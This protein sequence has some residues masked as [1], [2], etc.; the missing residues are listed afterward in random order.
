MRHLIGH[1]SIIWGT[2]KKMPFMLFPMDGTSC[3]HIHHQYSLP[4]LGAFCAASNDEE[5]MAGMK[6]ASFYN[7]KHAQTPENVARIA[8]AGIR[9]GD[10]L[11]T[12]TPGLGPMA[13]ILTRGFAPADTFMRNLVEAILSLPLRL[14]TSLTHADLVRRLVEIH[15]KHNPAGR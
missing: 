9:A 3:E 14:I 12:T 7:R 15:R 6:V 10:F 1:L 11:I 5:L 2:T 4:V 8:L 13:A